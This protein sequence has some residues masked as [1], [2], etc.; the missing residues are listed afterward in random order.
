MQSVSQDGTF[1]LDGETWV[2]PDF[3]GA[4]LAN[5][6]PTVLRL[7]APE[8]GGLEVPP[9]DE[10]VLPRRVSEGVRR[11]VVLLADGLGHLQLQRA[12]AAG[13]APTLAGLLERAAAG[14]D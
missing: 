14:D 9:L 11:V 3:G 1:A 12:I 8:A 13:S 2:R 5:L 6:A 10:G 4:G 7:L